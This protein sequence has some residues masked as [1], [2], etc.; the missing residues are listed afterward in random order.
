MPLSSQ[1]VSHCN[2]LK[3]TLNAS[4][5]N[6]EPTVCQS[7]CVHV[8][9]ESPHYYIHTLQFISMWLTNHMA[10]PCSHHRL[11][12]NCFTCISR[13]SSYIVMRVHWARVRHGLD[14]LLIFNWSSIGW[15]C[16]WSHYLLNHCLIC[17]C[18]ECDDWFSVICPVV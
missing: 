12:S 9:T 11:L 6:I 2:W 3:P 1:I 10:R 18:T 17:I 8:F 14:I 16:F 7:T 5:S 4:G 13:K 15:Y